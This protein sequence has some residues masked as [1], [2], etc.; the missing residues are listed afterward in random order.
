MNAGIR[1][2]LRKWS[3]SAYGAL[4]RGVRRVVARAEYAYAAVPRVYHSGDVHPQDRLPRGVLTLS[5]DFELAWAWPYARNSAEDP[6][7][8]GLR[9]RAQVP[10]L[11]KLFGDLHVPV[12]WATVG[13]LFLEKCARS[14]HGRAHDQMARIP[15]FETPLWRY[16]FGDW[17]QYDPCSDVRSDPAWYGPD[18]VEQ[19]LHSSERHEVACHGFS[20]VGFGPYCPSDVVSDE[21]RA[22]ADAMAVFGLQLETFVFPGNDE[23]NFPSLIRHGIGAVRAFPRPPGVITLPLRR[24][25]GLWA[26]HVTSALDRGRE[27]SIPERV[28]RLQ[29]FVTCAARE[30]LSAHIWLHPSLPGTEINEVL[31]PLLLHAVELRE[32]GKLDIMTNAGL[33]AVT[34][35]AGMQLPGV[36]HTPLAQEDGRG[37]P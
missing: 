27:W 20:H 18:L 13:H 5:I 31:V 6:V 19:I 3:R 25:D 16:S 8:K 23:G 4:P 1:P 2:W 17:F 11:L 15:H 30:R 36:D 28:A 10:R 26:H 14:A 9:E 24:R 12:T 21:L 22:C 7:Q 37:M 34:R 33:V 35:G 32:T 29:R